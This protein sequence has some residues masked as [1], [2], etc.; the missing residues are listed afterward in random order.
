MGQQVA[1]HQPDCG[2]EAARRHAMLVTHSRGDGMASPTPGCL[3]L[4]FILLR[5]GSLD[6]FGCNHNRKARMG[7][8]DEEELSR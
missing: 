5:G 1:K 4:L 3:P 6:A 2:P 7:V 8:M